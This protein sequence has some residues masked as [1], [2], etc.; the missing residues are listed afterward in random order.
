MLWL[1]RDW[2]RPPSL[3]HKRGGRLAIRLS[4]LVENL[5]RPARGCGVP[6]GI[7]PSACLRAERFALKSLSQKRFRP[8]VEPPSAPMNTK[9][10]RRESMKCLRR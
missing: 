6:L 4:Y 8:N 2:L 1:R 10:N 7:G 3:S 9:P 5:A